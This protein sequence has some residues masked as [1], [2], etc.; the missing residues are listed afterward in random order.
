MFLSSHVPTWHLQPP[1]PSCSCWPWLSEAASL[2]WSSSSS[3][4]CPAGGA[5]S[6]DR[7]RGT[8]ARRP[9]AKRERTPQCGKSERRERGKEEWQKNGTLPLSLLLLTLGSGPGLTFSRGSS[10]SFLSCWTHHFQFFPPLHPWD[11]GSGPPGGHLPSPT[12][13]LSHEV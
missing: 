10:G 9:P 11:L 4:L 6:G 13:D 12:V 1:S 7:G 3:S 5:R 8:G 2:L